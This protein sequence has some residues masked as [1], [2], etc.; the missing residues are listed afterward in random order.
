MFPPE[1]MQTSLRP[2]TRPE[3]AA[4]S[5]E[6]AGALGD[7]PRPLGEEAHRGGGVVE[8]D[9]LRTGEQRPGALP[10]RRQDDLG[11][12]AVDERGR[13]ARR[14]ARL[15]RRERGADGGAGLGLD[16]VD[17]GRRAGRRRARSRSR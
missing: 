5:G 15:A 16:R 3:S 13:E 7:H 14:L 4:A 2:G 1:T 17:P 8:R 12:C 11:A 9:R 6:R 10:H